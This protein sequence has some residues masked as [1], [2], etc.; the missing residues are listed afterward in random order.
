MCTH[1]VLENKVAWTEPYAF[2][3]N[4]HF[5]PGARKGGVEFDWLLCSN[6]NNFSSKPQTTFSGFFCV[7]FPGRVRSSGSPRTIRLTGES[8]TAF[9]GQTYI[10]S[11]TLWGGHWS[12]LFFNP[13][14]QGPSG[15]QGIPGDVGEAG[16][17]VRTDEWRQPVQFKCM[18]I[19]TTHA[20]ETLWVMLISSVMSF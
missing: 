12:S 14:P 6:I 13:I 17:M 5:A 11:S 10:F 7:S 16:P 1:T 3:A 15:G 9:R 4:Q 2:P 8:L 19:W 18:F 20:L